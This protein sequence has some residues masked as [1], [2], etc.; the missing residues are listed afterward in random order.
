MK[1]L[2]VNCVYQKGSTGKIVYDI[3]RVLQ[4]EQIDS[5]VC[6]GRG[7][8]IDGAYKTCSELYSKLN[9]LLS[10]FTGLMYGGCR[11]STWRL[12][13][14]IKKE[15]PD[16]VH[17]QCINGYF[18]N[19]YRL[20]TWLK[21]SGIQTV[22]TLHAE[23]MHTGNCGHAF[24]C[25]RWKDGCNDCPRWKK[26]TL[27]LF[28]NRTHASWE[29]MR[30]A[31]E[32]FE[33]LR[34]VSVSPWL[35]ERAKQSPILAECNHSVILNGIDTAV[36]APSDV[37]E[38]RKKYA[39][40][41]KKLI[42]FATATFTDDP[43]HIKGGYYALKL[44][45]RMKDEN[46]HFLVAAGVCD[47]KIKWHSNM[48]F[49]GNIQDQKILA[50]YYSAADLCLVLSKREAFSMPTSESLC[51]GTPVVG[52]EAGAPETISIKEY[53]RFVPYGDLEALHKAVQDSL[54]EPKSA[55]LAKLAEKKYSK[56][57]MAQQ[58]IALYRQMLHADERY[59]ERNY[60]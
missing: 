55:E 26:E 52:F 39:H 60:E 9:N 24:E 53:C 58:Y 35:M 45:E 4:T 30:K 11:L 22:L 16:I 1:V 54:N 8:R 15:N 48:T 57:I 12:I 37:S 6:Y 44:A 38:L 13:R 50:K 27:S 36:F 3:H 59:S 2:Q 5:V 31:F 47:S 19:I 10:R 49:L 23:F 14:V 7:E 28:F 43:S 29:K 17:L 32:G 21:K 33:K 41:G 56:E 34:V 42:F 46:V 51:C 25:E 20:I 18:V 40:D